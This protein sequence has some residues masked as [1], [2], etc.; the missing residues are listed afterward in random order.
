[1]LFV[2]LLVTMEI[3][4]KCHHYAHTQTHTSMNVYPYEDPLLT[5]LIPHIPYPSTRAV[6]NTILGALMR[7]NSEYSKLQQ[8][9]P[10]F[11][12]EGHNH[13]SCGGNMHYLTTAL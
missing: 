10:G 6:P 8:W 12:F 2:I 3:K 7:I 9:S 1:M 5:A 13:G 4:I 11:H